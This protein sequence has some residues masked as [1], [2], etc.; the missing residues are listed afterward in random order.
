MPQG[1]ATASGLTPRVPAGIQA[2]H[3]DEIRRRLQAGAYTPDQVPG[4][5]EKAGGKTL[6]TVAGIARRSHLTAETA[7]AREFA[8]EASEAR[9]KAGYFA[10]NR[11]VKHLEE[12]ALRDWAKHKGMLCDGMQF[13]QKWKLGGEQQGAEHDVYFDPETQRWFKRNHLTY[14]GN[15]LE[16]FQRLQLH[17]WLFPATTLKLEG[18]ME[19]DQALLPLLSQAHVQATRG[20]TREEVGRLMG[21]AGFAPVGSASRLDDYQ[22]PVLGIEVNDLHDEN[23]LIG[24]S[25]EIVIFDPVPMLMWSGKLSRLNAWAAGE[26]AADGSEK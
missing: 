19:H 5:A 11:T 14:H 2:A 22:H 1:D 24:E 7:A 18:F 4:G 21:E 16:Y 25:G 8:L 3:D 17:A 23:A 13:E 6:Q 10:V 20:A 9:R 15:W 26:A 12:A